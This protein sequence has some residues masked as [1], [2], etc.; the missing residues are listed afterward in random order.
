MGESGNFHP[1]IG[2]NGIAIEERLP[3][4][5]VN[6]DIRKPIEAV[7]GRGSVPPAKVDFKA[8]WSESGDVIAMQ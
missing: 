7:A 1:S 5:C 8:V 2:R 4:L 6:A 3:L